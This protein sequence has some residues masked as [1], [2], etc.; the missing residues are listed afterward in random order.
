MISLVAVDSI[1][2]FMEPWNK[3][4]KIPFVRRLTKN[5]EPDIIHRSDFVSV[6]EMN[7]N[8][9]KT[10]NSGT[11]HCDIYELRHWPY[12]LQLYLIYFN[13]PCGVCVLSRTP[14]ILNKDPADKRPKNDKSPVSLKQEFDPT[15]E[16]RSH[17]FVCFIRC[18]IPMERNCSHEEVWL[19]AALR[20]QW[21]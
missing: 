18:V 5:F 7:A 16:R 1:F 6:L 17:L 2:W 11:F 12:Y 21:W 10:C 19:K 13:V 14:N 20:N 8:E 9:H 15:G 4:S 3:T